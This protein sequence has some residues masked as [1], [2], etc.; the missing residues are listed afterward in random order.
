MDHRRPCAAVGCGPG[1]SAELPL[2]TPQKPH[3][4]MKRVGPNPRKPVVRVPPKR[5]A[6]RYR[7]PRGS[8]N[9]RPKRVGCGRPSAKSALAGTGAGPPAVG[10]P[11]PKRGPGRSGGGGVNFPRRPAGPAPPVGGSSAALRDR[12]PGARSPQGAFAK[13]LHPPLS[14]QYRCPLHGCPLRGSHSVGN[15]PRTG[16]WRRYRT[17]HIHPQGRR[18]V[19]PLGPS[20]SGPPGPVASQGRAAV[21]AARF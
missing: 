16:H 15:A 4:W 7:L 18:P 19:G 17:I 10:G 9:T 2:P 12:P 11:P 8:G 5:V 3:R 21:N 6:E 20:G 14:A 13:E 1:R